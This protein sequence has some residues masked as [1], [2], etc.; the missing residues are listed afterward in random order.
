MAK[1]VEL[2]LEVSLDLLRQQFVDTGKISKEAFDEIENAVGNKSAYATWLASRVAGGLI[3]PEDVYKFKNYFMVF[4]RRKRE[5][6]SSD[7]NSYKDEQAINDFIGKS[8]EILD[9]EK[10]DISSQKGVSKSNKYS[11]LK[12]GNVNGFDIYKLPKGR[13]DLYGASCELGS[14]TQWCTATGNTRTYFDNYINLDDLYIITDGT[15]M[16]QFSYG[17]RQFMDKRD[18]SGTNFANINKIYPFF[19][20]IRDK[21]GRAIP[22]KAVNAKKKAGEASYETVSMQFGKRI[23]REGPGIKGTYDELKNK[24]SKVSRSN[25]DTVAQKLGITWDN[26]II[27]T[28]FGTDDQ[29]TTLFAIHGIDKDGK[30]YMY[31]RAGI[32]AGGYSKL[33]SLG[34]TKVTV[35][36]VTSADSKLTSA[37]F[38]ESKLPVK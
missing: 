5:Y 38:K 1:L 9:T 37:D 32:G 13:E 36:A 31:D 2:L 27:Y 35:S 22:Q 21:E 33:Y 12:I 18:R 28:V 34:G 30:E 25:A 17:A 24:L 8:I 26:M 29:P 15:D 16:Y 7:I 20:F 4:D 19:E 14:G 10:G 6:P 11:S 3:K 23:K